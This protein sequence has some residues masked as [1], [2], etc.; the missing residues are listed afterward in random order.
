MQSFADRFVRAVHW[1]IAISVV[2]LLVQLV[3]TAVVARLLSP[4]DFGL[5]AIANVAF[6]IAVNV[7]VGLVST[8]TREPSLD[9]EVVGSALLL[10]C[11]VSAILACAMFLIAPWASSFGGNREHSDLIRVLMQLMSARI[12]V[13]GVGTPAQALLQRDLRFRDLGLIQSAGLL[14]GTGGTTIALAQAGL[15]SMSLLWGDIANST[16]VSGAC[17]W[18]VR[19]RW[20][21]CC[22]AAHVSRIGWISWQ[23]TLLRA[24]D[25]LWT[26]LPILVAR[27]YLGPAAV[28]LYQRSQTLV[29]VGIQY[30][31]GRV[32]VVL[33]P[34][35]AARQDR[36][37]FIRD[38]V[39]PLVGLYSMF[40]FSATVFVALM[41]PD[42][43]R[44]FLGPAWTDAARTLPWIMIAFTALH[45]SQPASAQLEVLALLRPRIISSACG[46]VGFVV[47]SLFLVRPYGLQGIAAAAI[48]SGVTTTMINFAAVRHYLQVRPRELARWM[49]PST[50]VALVLLGALLILY[51]YFV[52]WISSPM[53]RLVVMLTIAIFVSLIGF[54]LLL[55]S[56][57]REVLSLYMSRDVPR[58]ASVTA[59]LLG[60]RLPKREPLEQG[61][62][63]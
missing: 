51:R 30:S 26:Q 11:S 39:A 40:L 18:C 42:I 21:T 58:F 9:S 33:Y 54:R 38:L 5:Y 17:W 29:D 32:S 52:V 20:S 10:S 19:G 36:S 23:M 1:S 48:L 41:A 14:I 53:F 63:G 34:V 4:A 43:V 45:L 2:T 28:G 12:L 60:L 59:K 27:A 13:V 44:V 55:G 8:I 56:K 16:I 50:G 37:V 61:L 7:S 31:T 24:L 6:M 25:V 46:A 22:N 3:I 49:I 47:S 15:G 35:M 62:T 57:R